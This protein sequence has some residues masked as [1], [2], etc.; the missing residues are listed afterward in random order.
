MALSGVFPNADIFI[1]MQSIAGH[2][3]GDFF[4]GSTIFLIQWLFF[5]YA[6]ANRAR[7]KPTQPV[8]NTSILFNVNLNV[9]KTKTG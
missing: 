9:H 4:F 2:S 6:H 5:K 1:S 8:L 7:G 3:S